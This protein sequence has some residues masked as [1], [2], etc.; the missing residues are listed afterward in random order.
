[1]KWFWFFRVPLITYWLLY[2]CRVGN[3]NNEK[4]KSKVFPLSVRKAFYGRG[5]MAPL[6]LSFDTRLGEWPN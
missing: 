1:M 5:R 6:I 2:Y 4:C 3:R